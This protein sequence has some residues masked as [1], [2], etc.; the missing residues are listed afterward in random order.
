MFVDGVALC[1]ADDLPDVRRC[2]EFWH[3][4]RLREEADEPILSG[5]LPR[6][7]LKSCTISGGGVKGAF[8][9]ANS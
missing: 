7:A 2:E 1:R 9:Q 3:R 8:W 5:W 6:R 4:H